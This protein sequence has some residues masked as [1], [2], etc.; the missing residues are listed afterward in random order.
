M[1]GEA[2]VGL[3][4]DGDDGLE[5]AP[6]AFEL[7]RPRVR[8]DAFPRRQVLRQRVVVGG[9]AGAGAAFFELV[10]LDEAMRV[11]VVLDHRQPELSGDL[12]RIDDAAVCSSAFGPPQITSLKPPI[13][14]LMISMPPALKRSIRALSSSSFHGAAGSPIRTCDTPICF[15]RR[16]WASSAVGDAEA[17]ARPAWAVAELRER[18]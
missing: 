15:R 9:V 3:L 17:D 2:H 6:G 4:G 18:D 13:I 8:A 12:D 14:M 5:E 16:I 7:L 11:E 10:A 1:Q